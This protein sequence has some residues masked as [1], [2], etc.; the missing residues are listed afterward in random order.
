MRLQTKL[1]ITISVVLTIIIILIGFIFIFLLPSNNDNFE[2]YDGSFPLPLSN[3]PECQ[4]CY[5]SIPEGK[6]LIGYVFSVTLNNLTINR[7]YI[8]IGLERSYIFTALKNKMF[9][10][11]IAKREDYIIPEIFL[12]EYLSKPFIFELHE[13][14]TYEDFI[15]LDKLEIETR[16]Y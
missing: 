13:L 4:N 3:I 16:R 8:Y 15:L 9:L 1:N 6:L 7:T 11:D 12:F 14:S 5:L 10:Y 2:R